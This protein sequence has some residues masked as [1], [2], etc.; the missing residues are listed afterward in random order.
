LMEAETSVRHRFL[1]SSESSK[2]PDPRQQTTL[3]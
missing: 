3:H 2:T 1:G